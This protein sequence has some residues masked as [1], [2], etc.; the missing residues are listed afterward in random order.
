M[1]ALE[2]L[3]HTHTHIQEDLF[4]RA[5]NGKLSKEK[6]RELKVYAREFVLQAS[7]K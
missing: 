4:G 3:A 1:R 6:R 5:L 7:S 2:E